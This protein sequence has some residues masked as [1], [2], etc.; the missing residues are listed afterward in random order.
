MFGFD[1]LVMGLVLNLFFCVCCGVELIL[2]KILIGVFRFVNLKLLFDK[3][4]FFLMSDL[5]VLIL[6]WE[7]VDVMVGVVCFCVLCGILIDVCGVIFLDVLI[8]EFILME[9][10]FMVLLWV[11]FFGFIWESRLGVGVDVGWGVMLWDGGF[12]LGGLFC[13]FGKWVMILF[14]GGLVVDGF[15]GCC[16]CGG[17]GVSGFVLELVVCGELELLLWGIFSCCL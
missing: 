2:L 3:V 14:F 1:F 5:I 7:V 15:F 8:D 4:L 12:F 17:M 16:I 10:L 9:V 11:L 6:F 13:W